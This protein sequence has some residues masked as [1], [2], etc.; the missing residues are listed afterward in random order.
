LAGRIVQTCGRRRPTPPNR[1]WDQIVN[2]ALS[3]ISGYRWGRLLPPVFPREAGGLTR[4]RVARPFLAQ[5]QRPGRRRCCTPAAWPRRSGSCLFGSIRLLRALPLTRVTTAPLAVGSL[6]RDFG[7]RRAS[8]LDEASNLS[9][10]NAGG[11]GLA[12]RVQPRATQGKDPHS[13][14]NSR[15]PVWGAPPR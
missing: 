4:A 9:N 12:R 6:L 11:E 5:Y 10:R 13:P 7:G 14:E 3:A 2:I 1:G 8:P 15:A